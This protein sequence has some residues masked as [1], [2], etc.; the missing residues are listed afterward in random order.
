M[1]DLVVGDGYVLPIIART[2]AR[3]MNRRLVAPLS[4]WQNDI[5][6]LPHWYSES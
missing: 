6:S 5:A 3:A 2:S 4:G 1:N